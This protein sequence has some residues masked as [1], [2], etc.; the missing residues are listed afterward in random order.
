MG[1]GQD[2]YCKA[3]KLIPGGTQLLSKR[4]EM[5]LPGE[6]PA[7]Y[8]KANGCKIWDLDNN[9]YTDM[10]YMGIGACV[11]GYADPDVDAAVK[12]GI[13]N[14]VASTLN[15]PEELMLAEKLLALH[16]WAD[17]VRYAS[18]GG[19]SLAMAIRIARASTGK[20]KVLFCG[21]HG[22]H[23]WYISSN[24]ADDK[25]LDGHLL[26]G[27]KPKGVPRA[28]KGTSIPFKYNDTKEFLSLVEK[29]GDEVGVVIIEAIRNF[30]PEEGFLETIRRI[31]REKGI[32]FIIDEVSSGFRLATGGAHLVLGIEPDMAVFSKALANGY[33]MA[34]VIGRAEFMKA[35][36]D[37]F[38]SSTNWTCN[39]GLNA[40]LAMI[41]KYEANDVSTHLKK[42]GEDVQSGWASLA[43]KHG[44][45]IKLS[46]IYP[47][48][49]FEFEYD[50]ALVLKT[51][52]TKFMLEKNFLATNAFYASFAHKDSDI[53]NYL[54]AVDSV[55][56]TIK[57]IID[58]GNPDEYIK[59]GVCH[60]GFK[61]LT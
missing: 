1:K 36:E 21:Y 47:M 49:H 42:I 46:G 50:N 52:F 18:T 44:L 6:W 32:I 17:M 51:L 33:P 2:L 12:A 23:D 13:D 56:L 39:V 28:L 58:E 25:S 59:L 35:A 60:S 24:L 45:K 19:E 41:K 31:T 53:K 10:S 20:D 15:S 14:G 3:K 34:A 57:K 37:S 43:E 55:F 4:P 11:L 5:F 40:A 54:S 26:S 48:S 29:H 30:Y 61:R 16:P 27:L 9:E 38:I 7:Y 22:W 8:Q